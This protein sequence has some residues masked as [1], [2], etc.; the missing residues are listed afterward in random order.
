MSYITIFKFQAKEG[1][2]DALVSFFKRILPET[3]N[4]TGNQNTELS[5]LSEHEF[6]IT[7]HWEREENLGE[8]LNWREE[9][10]DFAILLS[11]LTQ[12]PNIENHEVLE[13][14]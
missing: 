11:F 5:R 6:M 8:Y 10:G 2:S 7:A 1:Q 4:C 12:A 3:R 14:V 13:G 9:K